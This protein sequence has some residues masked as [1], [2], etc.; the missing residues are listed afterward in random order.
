MDD[1]KHGPFP[2]SPATQDFASAGLDVWTAPTAAFTRIAEAQNAHTG[3]YDSFTDAYFF[4]V[5]S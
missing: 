1:T 3:P 5:A 4:C 2:E